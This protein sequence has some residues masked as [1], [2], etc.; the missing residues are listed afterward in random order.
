MAQ[1]DFYVIESAYGRDENLR[2]C[3]SP[4]SIQREDV[5][6]IERWRFRLAISKARRVILENLVHFSIGKTGVEK[7]MEIIGA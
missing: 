2:P 3:P 4:P 1:Q 5:H 7:A 6:G